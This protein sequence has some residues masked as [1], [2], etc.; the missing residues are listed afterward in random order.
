MR[1]I[2]HQE[3]IALAPVVGNDRMELV[4]GVT[5]D[6]QNIGIDEELQNLAQG[7]VCPESLRRFPRQKFYF[8]AP[9]IARA[10]DMRAGP[11]RPA[12]LMRAGRQFR[13]VARMGVDDDPPFVEA[14][15]LDG[16]AAGVAD[17]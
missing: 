12:V 8:P 6:I 4:D 5:P 7:F 10:Y 15:I 2:A 11:R 3:H 1:C 14:E 13:Q 9:K 17:G 16:D